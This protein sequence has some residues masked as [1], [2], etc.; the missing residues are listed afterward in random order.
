VEYAPH[1]DEDLQAM[2]AVV[3]RSSLDELF[4]HIPRALRPRGEPNLPHGR[5]E[6]ETL[7]ELSRYAAANRTDAVC[8]AG[9]GAYDHYVPAVVGALISRGELLTSYTPYQPEVSQGMLQALFEYQTV[10][11]ELTG[12]PVSNAS[13]YD[14]GSAVAE[15]VSMAC[16]ATHRNRVVMST[17]LDAPSRTVVRTY[18]HPLGREISE[19]TYGPDGRTPTLAA[20]AADVAAVIIQQPNA[21]GV[22]EDVR[23]HAEAAHAVGAQ[24]IVKLEATSVGLLAT[25]GSLGA[26]LVIGEGQPLG[27]GLAYGGP[28][29]GFLACRDDQVR[30]IPGRIVGRTVDKHGR[31]GYVMTLRAREQDIRRERAT[32]NICTN[33]TLNAVAALIYL[34]WLGPQGLHQL[35]E[36]CLAR[37][38][39]AAQRL[40]EI[41]GVELAVTGPFIKEFALRLPV[42]DPQAAVAALHDAGYLVG[43]VVA[44][45]PA[46]GAVMIATTERRTA[47]DVEGLA[48]ALARI[49]K[50]QP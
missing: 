25:P 45:G 26:D 31:R 20:D 42:A 14:G 10:I 47:A 23:A 49:I 48:D 15:A 35:A 34:S 22:V 41:D 18:G 1:T 13:L 46:A 7:G 36:V 33:Q 40:T 16:A 37:A 19:T 30:R 32:S 44:D 43:P 2:L 38:R 12:L 8:F 17:G 5:S 28:T 27:Q 3:G 21:L 29:F 6:D 11:S 24:L 9:G 50:E 39:H 4:E